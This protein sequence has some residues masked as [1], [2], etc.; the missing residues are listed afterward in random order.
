LEERV[1]VRGAELRRTERTRVLDEDARGDV[2][3][4][5]LAEEVVGVAGE[6]G[7]DGLFGAAFF[8]RSAATA[9]FCARSSMVAA[10]LVGNERRWRAPEASRQSA[11]QEPFL[12]NGM[13]SVGGHR[14]L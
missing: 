7:R 2:G 4:S 6:D 9:A 13:V 5:G 14:N 11:N 8:A 10:D 12:R 3:L 1:D